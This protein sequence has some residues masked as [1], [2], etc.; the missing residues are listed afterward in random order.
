M[1]KLVLSLA[2][3]TGSMAFAQSSDI[4]FGAKAGVNIS[5]MTNKIGDKKVSEDAKEKV[6]Y[7]A[8]LFVNIPV[9]ES[10]SVQPEVL[11]NNVGQK[12]DYKALGQTVSIKNNL[13]YISVPV[14]AQYN[15]AE[16]LYVEAGP[17]FSFLVNQKLKV[18][19]VDN[20]TVTNA[21]E[22]TLNVEN[23]KDAYKTFDLG[24]GLGAGYKVYKN[25]GV[26]AR[27]VVGL[28]NDGKVKDTT[29][30]N[31]TFQVGVTVGF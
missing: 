22:S 27:Y 10:F 11:Y 14:M 17:Q 5:T 29:I 31:N 20:K 25:I 12:F 9:S 30:K 26:N 1:K 7:Y 13:D 21:V 3:M 28:T 23:S 8:G 16:G 24:L 6:G 19:G 4:G 15:V 2:V 18:S